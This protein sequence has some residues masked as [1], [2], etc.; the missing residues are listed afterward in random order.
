MREPTERATNGVEPENDLQQS[1]S[2]AELPE[3][4]LPIVL[5]LSSM[6]NTATPNDETSPNDI[7]IGMFAPHRVRADRPDTYSAETAP[8]AT[9]LE[10]RAQ[11]RIASEGE[12]DDD[13]AARN[14]CRRYENDHG[15]YTGTSTHEEIDRNGDRGNTFLVRPKT[16]VQVKE[17]AMKSHY[18]H[19]R[20]RI[21]F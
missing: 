3:S 14:E 18:R 4:H 11:E 5:S 21:K 16:T 8:D 9:D 10:E 7:T 17:S 19:E 15:A 12:S 20:F 13:P 1:A 2:R 6:E